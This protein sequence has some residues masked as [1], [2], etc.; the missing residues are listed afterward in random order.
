MERL[1]SFFIGHHLAS[2]EDSFE[3]A[4]IKL[5]F[6]F[7]FYYLMVATAFVP[8][9]FTYQVRSLTYISLVFY[10]LCAIPFILLRYSKSYE[11]PSFVFSIILIFNASTNS[12][13]NN[14]LLTPNISVWYFIAVAFGAYTLRLR[15]IITLLVLLYLNLSVINIL[16]YNDLLNINPF[17]SDKENLNA[18]PFIMIATF[19][20]MFK[21]LTEYIRSKNQ[22]ISDL[23]SLIAEKDKILG[24]V[25]HDLRNPIGAAVSCIEICQK[26]WQRETGKPEHR[27]FKLASESCNRALGH[28]EDLLESCLLHDNTRP[29]QTELTE[30]AP[31]VS[32]IAEGY[33]PKALQ[34]RIVLNFLSPNEKITANINKLRLS[35]AIDNLISNAIKFTHENG[36]IEISLYKEDGFAVIRISDTGIGIPEK[37]QNSLFEEF[38]PAARIG[39]ADERSVGLGMYIVKQIVTFHG[40]DISFKT[41]ENEGTSFFVRIP[42]KS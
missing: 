24:V 42:T 38:T 10:P 6:N 28:M 22:A 7:F 37:L 8:F 19:P 23:K 5:I 12:I 36:T 11:I 39:T 27:F 30:L 40:G 4:R 18:T 17:F 34:K 14:G 3:A 1:R 21:L 29:I 20:L 2:A 16:R 25:A 13:L 26:D 32:S 33:Q 35:R 9:L 15:Y 41:K 31:F